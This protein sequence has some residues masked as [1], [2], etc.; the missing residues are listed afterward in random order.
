MGETV[1][2]LGQRARAI[3]ARGDRRS[4]IGLLLILAGVLILVVAVVGAIVVNL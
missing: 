3:R 1:R 4:R 2:H